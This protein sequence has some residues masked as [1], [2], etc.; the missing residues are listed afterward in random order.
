M[1]LELRKS[2]GTV[3]VASR[4]LDS[5]AGRAGVK[6]FS[7]VIE[8]NYK[9]MLFS[10]IQ[11]FRNWAKNAPPQE[12]CEES[13]L[14]ADCTRVRMMPELI[15]EEIPVYWSPNNDRDVSAHIPDLHCGLEFCEKTGQYV[16]T[17]KI[18]PDI[19]KQIY[20]TDR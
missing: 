16:H 4:L 1:V 5:P 14:F 9:P 15:D 11:D 10:G 8:I 12:G 18:S 3:W 7:Q 13:F 19:L 6:L 2:D 20:F 17:E